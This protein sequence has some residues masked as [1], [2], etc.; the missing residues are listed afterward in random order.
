M[1][2]LLTYNLGVRAFEERDYRTAVE[3]FAEVL[4]EQPGNRSVREYLAR[5]HFHRASLGP[6]EE[7]CRRILD[8]DPTDEYATLLLAR[9]LE[10]QNKI[11]EAAG[12]RR[13][14]AALTGDPAHLRSG[15]LT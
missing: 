2:T 8:Q 11:D 9:T 6:A 13:R 3:R 12:V 15:S 4:E 10:R 1:T 5:A 14:L 7:Q